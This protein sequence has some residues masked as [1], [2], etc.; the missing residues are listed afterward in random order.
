MIV[1]PK[2]KR[3]QKRNGRKNETGAKTAVACFAPEWWL[4]SSRIVIVPTS[5]FANVTLYRLQKQS[6]QKSC[7]TGIFVPSLSWQFNHLCIKTGSKRIVFL[8]WRQKRPQR[9][10]EREHPLLHQP[11]EGDRCEHFRV[12]RNFE[13]RL[14]SELCAWLR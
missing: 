9:C 8:P 2:T 13:K 3:A 5:G 6:F 14:E 4:S 12:A 11:V 10:V 1:F 7:P